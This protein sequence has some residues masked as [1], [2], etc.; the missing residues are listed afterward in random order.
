[1]ADGI[2]VDIRAEQ[3]LAQ[4]TQKKDALDAAM[5]RVLTRLSVEVQAGVKTNRLSGQSLHVR[6]GTLRRSINRLVVQTGDGVYAQVGTNVAYAGVHEYGF[7]G[8]VNVR[9]HVRQ[10]PSGEQNVRA[11]TRRVDLPARSFL[12]SEL[13]SRADDIRAQ[14]RKAA[15]EALK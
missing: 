11:H 15:V 3:F 13:A 2:T 9:A 6:T 12:R 10:M 8:I 1:M 5:L 7:Q 14:I 4:L